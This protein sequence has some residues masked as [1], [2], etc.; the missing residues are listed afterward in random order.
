MGLSEMCFLTN[1]E[2]YNKS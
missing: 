2:I 1:V